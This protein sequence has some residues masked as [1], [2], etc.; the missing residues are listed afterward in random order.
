MDCYRVSKL[1]N[2]ARND[3]TDCITAVQKPLFW[4]AVMRINY[5]LTHFLLPSQQNILRYSAIFVAW[6]GGTWRSRNRSLE[7][8]EISI[9][10]RLLPV[11]SHKSHITN[12]YL[13]P[14]QQNMLRNNAIFVAG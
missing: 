8:L 2:N 14:S 1:A 13:L 7:G 4:T 10:C 6:G 11:A 5:G 3:S 9:W 12:H